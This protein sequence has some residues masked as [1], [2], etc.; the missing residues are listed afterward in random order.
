MRLKN[1]M[2]SEIHTQWDVA[3]LET[4]IRLKMVP[5]SLRWEVCPQKGETELEEWFRYFNNA[6]TD[7]LQFLVT[8]K[9]DKLTR[10]DLEIKT[11]KDSLLPYKN[12]EEYKE[13]TSSLIKTLDKEEREQKIK[14]RKKYN[15]DYD[16]YQASLVFEWQKKIMAEQT[17]HS[18]PRMEAITQ[19]EECPDTAPTSSQQLPRT[20]QTQQTSK[21]QSR[22][23]RGDKRGRRASYQSP[24]RV[25]GM[26]GGGYPKKLTGD[27]TLPPQRRN[28][29]YEYGSPHYKGPFRDQ[30]REHQYPRR[31]IDRT[32]YYDHGPNRHY[33]YEYRYRDR[34]YSERDN[35]YGY[36]FRIDTQNR[37][38]PLSDREGP[39]E[40]RSGNS[41][42]Y[43]RDYEHVRPGPSGEYSNNRKGANHSQQD[44]GFPRPNQGVKRPVENK[45]EPEGGGEHSQK[46]SRK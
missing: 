10:L 6:G 1:L 31:E 32:P 44:W 8:R 43:G 34:T 37:F 14:K 39:T 5:R 24:L 28:G 3:F 26:P 19:G 22:N 25:R 12:G 29:H 9:K 33:D 18:D 20:H 23:V 41:A 36:D 27:H 38:F 40:L 35:D 2:V 7:F 4:Y 11:L 46:K 45:E 30:G 42:N 21:K 13:R 16:D 15:R 17:A